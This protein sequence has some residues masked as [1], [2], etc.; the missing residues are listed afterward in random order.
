M[1][2]ASLTPSFLKKSNKSNSVLGVYALLV[3]FLIVYAIASPQS[4]TGTHLMDVALQAAPLG[5][6]AIGQTI[7]LLL[8]GIDLSVG[9]VI[10]LTNVIL[11]GVMVGQNGRMGIAVIFAL[12][13]AIAIGIINGVAVTKLKI[14]PFLATL[15]M[16]SIVEGI[17][18]V[19]TK[20]SP[21]GNIASGFRW[22]SNGWFVN[23]LP[24]AVVI[25][26]LIW[27]I[28]AFLL[29]RTSFGR[30]L[31]ATG[32][33]DR[34][35]WL[36]GIPTNYIIIGGYVLSSVLASLSGFLISAYIGVASIGVGDPYTLNSVAAAVIGGAAFTGGRG[37]LSGTFAGVLIM[38]FLQS[39]LTALNVSSA[40][41]LI[42]QG[43][44]IVVMVAINQ[45]RSKA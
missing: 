17:Y 36:S 35:A 41:Q 8:A 19:Y 6:V 20:G 25:W 32:G 37:G 15:A 24:W 11:A 3:A 9:S 13:V 4:F 43:I 22:M 12:V 44:V 42:S 29:Y 27:I 21:I 14:P 5:V 18:Y 2:T 39:L 1:R 30:R 40:G 45:W 28:A 7:V 26:I 33:N 38:E 16:G 34:T 10:T 31:Y 23:I